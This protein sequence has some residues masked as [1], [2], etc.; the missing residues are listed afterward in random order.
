MPSSASSLDDAILLL[1]Q[2]L[3]D[4]RS[5]GCT[6]FQVV[7]G[8]AATSEGVEE[9]GAKTPREQASKTKSKV[10]TRPAK[11]QS[12]ESAAESEDPIQKALLLVGYAL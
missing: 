10:K 3:A 4:L 12:Q 5:Q 6:H 2:V 11:E 9:S 1:D 7:S 8:A